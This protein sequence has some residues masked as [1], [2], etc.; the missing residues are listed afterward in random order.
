LDS[1]KTQITKI[2]NNY[3][4]LEIKDDEAVNSLFLEILPVPSVK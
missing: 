1:F 2:Y 3:I 4:L